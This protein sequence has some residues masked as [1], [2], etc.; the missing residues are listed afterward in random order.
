MKSYAF[1]S[2]LRFHEGGKVTGYLV[3]FTDESERDMYGTYF[4]EDTDFKLDSYPIEG[5]NLLYHHGL[6]QRIGIDAI[7]RIS[8]AKIVR[9]PDEDGER[10]LWIQAQLNMMN[11]YVNWIMDADKTARASFGRGLGFS[12][13]ALPQSVE[14]DSNGHVRTWA[15]IEGSLT[16]TPADKLNQIDEPYLVR[17]SLEM[18][19]DT[20]M[21]TMTDIKKPENEIRTM[22]ELKELILTFI[23]TLQDTLNEMQ[24]AGEAQSA[25][26]EPVS[27][28]LANA[29]S[30]ED[31]MDEMVRSIYD[32]VKTDTA[33]LNRSIAEQYTALDTILKARQDE[34][35]DVAIK[36]AMDARSRRKQTLRAMLQKHAPARFASEGAGSVSLNPNK[37]ERIELGKNLRFAHL[38][39]AEMVYGLAALRSAVNPALRGRLSVG[40]L[41]SEDYAR[42]MM[43]RLAQRANNGKYG[44]DSVAIRSAMPFLRANEINAS[45][46]AGQGLEWTETVLGTVLWEKVR[47]QQIMDQLIRRGLFI[48]EVGQ[49][50]SG[51]SIP[52]EEA[53]PVAYTRSQSNDIN[54]VGAPEITANIKA[55]STGAKTITPGEVAVAVAITKVLDEDSIIPMLPQV[56]RQLTIKANETITQL[57]INGDTVTTA[58]TNINLIDGTPGTGLSKP[59]Y[60]A[61]DGIR[62]YA[63]VTDTTYAR[64]ASNTF[65]I[66]DFIATRK[67]MPSA[68][69]TRFA[70][71][72]YLL[73]ADT[74]EAAV[75]LPEVQS[76]LLAGTYATLVNGVLTGAYGV[77]VLATGFYPLTNT[78]GKVSATPGNNL[79]GNI[80]LIYAPYIAMAWKRQVSTETQYEMFS[81]TTGVLTSFRLGFAVRGAGGVALTYGLN[82]NI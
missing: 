45:D 39:D 33:M 4:D 63:V 69:R 80:A 29:M 76:P 31:T 46:I 60:L 74:A 28:A 7:G 78:A 43:S 53:D 72:F 55:I 35:I 25:E 23:T 5:Y 47:D 24:S 48:A 13:G 9:E 58:T 27:D 42:E 6:D 32:R 66:Q 71:M 41:V 67:L 11:P 40:D 70:N 34:L 81:G 57:L 22:D 3:R 64:N 36:T 62:K 17:A 56:I 49:G 18:K 68:V 51:I 12:S 44:E 20:N 26:V 8:E 82:V 65:S 52:T 1:G 16:L 54:S 2:S 37:Y 19:K 30:D 73:D 38:D 50:Q 59:Y 21:E 75:V 61:S 14:Y 77:D 79:Y 15:I 10:G